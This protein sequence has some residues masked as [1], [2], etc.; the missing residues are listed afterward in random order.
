[1]AELGSNIDM[2]VPKIKKPVASNGLN[3]TTRIVI[4]END[5]IPP[6]GLPIGLNGMV[7][8]IRPGEEVDVPPGVLEVLDHAVMSVPQV[9]PQTKQVVGYRD[10]MRYPYRVVTSG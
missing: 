7:Y 1:M 6:T 5:D 4:E 9:D 8:V 3:K 10:R 2:E